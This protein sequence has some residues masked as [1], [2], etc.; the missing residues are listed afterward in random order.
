MMWLSF[1]L[2]VGAGWAAGVLITSYRY[3]GVWRRYA[4]YVAAFN[5]GRVG[6]EEVHRYD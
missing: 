6:G 2:G 1:W 3:R 5:D 4:A